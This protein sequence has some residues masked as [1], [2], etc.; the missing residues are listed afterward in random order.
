MSG[1]NGRAAALRPA[2]QTGN[3][4]FASSFTIAGLTSVAAGASWQ[5]GLGVVL[6]PDKSTRAA[7][8]AVQVEFSVPADELARSEGAICVTAC[9]AVAIAVVSPCLQV[10]DMHGTVAAL[11]CDEL[12]QRIPGDTLDIVIVFRDLTNDVAILDV[13]D[14]RNEVGS[15]HSQRLAVGTPSHVVEFLLCGT[16]HKLD[17][18]E[19]LLKLT[20]AFE[21]GCDV[22]KA[23]LAAVARH[24]EQDVAIITGSS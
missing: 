7:V 15:S 6:V 18:P 21:V 5:C 23:R 13:D 4:A 3:K 11:R 2:P 1:V 24:P 8:S 16:A 19:L 22:A 17:S 9:I 10:V 20:F 14:A 12:V